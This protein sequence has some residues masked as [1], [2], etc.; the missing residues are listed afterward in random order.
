[1]KWIID[2]S[3]RF[4][5]RPYFENGELDSE[6]ENLISSFLVEK[7]GEIRYPILTNDLTILIEKETSGLDVYADLSKE[8]NN[9]E[10]MTIFSL[11][12]RPRVLISNNLST[13]NNQINR[14]RTTLTHE[15]GHVKFHNF[16]WSFEQST[17]FAKNSPNLTIRCNRENIINARDVDWLE[18]QAGYASGAFLMPFSGVKDIFNNIC[19]ET[20]MFG[21]I[22]LLSEIGQKMIQQIQT[23]FEVSADAA[24]VRLIKLD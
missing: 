14:Y 2:K 20:N 22:P 15:L 21:K 13:A 1:M 23:I 16:L 18:W 10:G 17:L 6:C 4:S 9:V 3:G 11:K 8:G 5:Q 19:R 24:R 7:Y 12:N